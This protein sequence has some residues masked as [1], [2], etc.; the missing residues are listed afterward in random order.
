[1]TKIISVA[2]LF[3]CATAKPEWYIKDVADSKKEWRICDERYDPQHKAKGFCY[4]SQ[5]CRKTWFGREK[6]EPVRLFCGWGDIECYRKYK[7]LGKK[8][9]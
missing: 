3:S 2:L 4:I 8:L 7:L 1:M 5:R 9:R 6:C